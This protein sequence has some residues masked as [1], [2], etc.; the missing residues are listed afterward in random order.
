LV[1]LITEAIVT[2]LFALVGVAVVAWVASVFVDFRL[3]LNEHANISHQIQMI[4]NAAPVQQEADRSS[5]PVR[6]VVK[7]LLPIIFW[8]LILLPMFIFPVILIVFPL[9]HIPWSYLLPP[10]G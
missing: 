9:M 10:T 1:G 3:F 8:L 5:K 6:L 2:I 7:D 4:F